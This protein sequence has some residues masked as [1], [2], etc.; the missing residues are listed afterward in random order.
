MRSRRPRRYVVDTVDRINLRSQLAGSTIGT[1]LSKLNSASAT[2]AADFDKALLDYMKARTTPT[3]DISPADVPGIVNFIKGSADADQQK[4]YNAEVLGTTTP[5]PGF[6]PV[7]PTAEKATTSETLRRKGVQYH[8][9][10]FQ[11][12]GALYPNFT[13]VEKLA[14]PGLYVDWLN[15]RT[16]GK[17]DSLTMSLHLQRLLNLPLTAMAY[18]FLGTAAYADTIANTLYTWAGQSPALSDA[19]LLRLYKPAGSASYTL[20]VPPGVRVLPSWGALDTGV[21]V[22]HLLTMYNLMLGTAKWTP[23]LNTLFLTLMFQHGRVLGETAK[24]LYVDETSR[25]GVNANPLGAHR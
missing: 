18:R 9:Y 12:G 25:F 13:P 8:V 14:T 5:P 20:D 2:F 7:K 6:S 19:A 4:L 3:F 1:T 17:I 22:H 15:P 11:V 10:N 23:E 21:R 16:F 24:A